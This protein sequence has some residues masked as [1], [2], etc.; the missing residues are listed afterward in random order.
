[1]SVIYLFG[2]SSEL[3][4]FT[5]KQ[6]QK[7]Q[8][9]RYSKVLRILREESFT[10]GEDEIIWDPSSAE[11]VDTFMKTLALGDG[12]LAIIATGSISINDSE[13]QFLDLS[14]KL[15]EQI[16]WVNLTLPL[17]LLSTVGTGLQEKG[18]GDIIIFTSAAALP[19]QRS[20]FIYSHSKAMLDTLVTRLEQSL[21]KAK[22][23]TLVV[24]SSFS[25]T[26]LN[27]GRQPTPLSITPLEL[28]IEVSKAHQN[29]KSRIWVP[30]I[31]AVISIFL[32]FVPG[33]SQVAN[34][35]VKKSK[36]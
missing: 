33:L 23:R 1:M 14:H 25:A 3:G 32:R 36:T 13:K 17:V 31:F 21:S 12:D 5:A 8:P 7:D 24:R 11:K 19:P 10:G 22:V 16:V 28:A 15:L 18:G 34:S 29:L 27:Q 2:G 26:P 35:I 6:I 9:A 4:N 30:R 20:N